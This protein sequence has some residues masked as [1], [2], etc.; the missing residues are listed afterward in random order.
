MISSSARMSAPMARHALRQT[1]TRHS[2]TITPAVS[3]RVALATSQRRMASTTAKVAEA[4]TKSDAPWAIGSLLVF[5]GMFI[6][7][8]APPKGGKKGHGHESHDTGS[9]SHDDEEESEDDEER[10]FFVSKKIEDK[11]EAGSDAPPGSHVSA[12]LFDLLQV[13]QLNL[14]FIFVYVFVLFFSFFWQHLAKNSLTAEEGAHMQKTTKSGGDLRRP[15]DITFQKGVAAAKEG[16]SGKE[17]SHI[18]DPKKVVASAHAEREDRHQKTKSDK[19]SKDKSSQDAKDVEES[20]Q[21]ADANAQN[22][23][24]DDDIEH[25]QEIHDSEQAKKAN[26][27]NEEEGSDKDD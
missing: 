26:A 13:R 12:L 10:E 17:G 27:I 5:G 11:P 24:S 23:E 25:S 20:A 4:A 18:S 6:Y 15:D 8:T 22:E 19:E 21:A 9:S 1:A 14:V 16:H 2:S 3:K 7:L